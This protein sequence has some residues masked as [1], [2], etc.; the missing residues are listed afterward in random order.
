V[1]GQ[2]VRG[3]LPDAGQLAQLGDEALDGRRVQG[4]VSLVL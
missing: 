1:E 3:P 2:P 4:V